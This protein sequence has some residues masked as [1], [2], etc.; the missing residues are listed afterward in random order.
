MSNTDKTVV[1]YSIIP[2]FGT[3][4]G[5]QR[6]TTISIGCTTFFVWN[7]K[8][9]SKA[10]SCPLSGYNNNC[11]AHDIACSVQQATCFGSSVCAGYHMRTC[12]FSY[13]NLLTTDKNVPWSCMIPNTCH[14][15]RVRY[16]NNKLKAIL[17][18]PK[19]RAENFWSS[20]RNS[21]QVP[22]KLGE[23]TGF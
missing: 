12:I 6:W 1:V 9:H 16:S 14:I 20:G 19:A 5:T 17:R 2:R 13:W 4:F 3:K 23:I 21:G 8:V 11:L 10:K 22:W 7:C 15:S 18:A